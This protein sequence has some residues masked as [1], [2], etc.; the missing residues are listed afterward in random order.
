MEVRATRRRRTAAAWQDLRGPGSR[1]RRDEEN[2]A[3]PYV[4]GKTGAEVAELAADA[5]EEAG[6]VRMAGTMTEDGDEMEV[7]LQLQDDD[8]AY[9]LELEDLMGS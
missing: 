1:G 4:Q 6:A 9:A 8:P 7:D 3:H 2:H 5:L